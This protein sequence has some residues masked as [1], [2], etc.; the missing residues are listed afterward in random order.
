MSPSSPRVLLVVGVLPYP[1]HQTTHPPAIRTTMARQ[2]ESHLTSLVFIITSPTISDKH[3]ISPKLPEAD[4][5][6]QES[7]ASSSRHVSGFATHRSLDGVEGETSDTPRQ[8]KEHE[9]A[10]WILLDGVRSP[11]ILSCNHQLTSR[12]DLKTPATCTNV[13]LHNLYPGEID[14]VVCACPPYLSR[15]TINPD[16]ISGPNFGRNTSAA[17]SLSSGTIGA[18]MSAALSRTRAIA[19]SYGNVL[20][21]TP[22][23]LHEPALN[24][25]VRIV[26]Y[27]WTNWGKDPDG[28]RDGDVDLYN[29]NLPMI[30][31]LADPEGLQ[32]YWTRIW[33]NSY[34]RLFKRVPTVQ[35]TQREIVPDDPDP[36]TGLI[37]AG[38]AAQADVYLAFKFAPD[39]E[40]LVNPDLS[41]VPVGTDGWA[42]GMGHASITPMR[43]GFAEADIRGTDS[44][45]K[46][47]L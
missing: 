18:A 7:Q 38:S 10:E 9:I 2:V 37:S 44:P 28:I 11:V 26:E 14:L 5:S 42:F 15:L 20:R 8:L 25:S 6:I 45:R 46:L 19:I 3:I 27:L 23:S 22:L 39:I 43:S 13:A 29:V 35:G 21:P 31:K 16:Q 40:P 30:H 4:I 12:N 47:N 1:P 41:V 36:L 33:R 17:L 34:G 24:L 32:V